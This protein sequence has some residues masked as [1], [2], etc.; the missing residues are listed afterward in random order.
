METP[1]SEM[2]AAR[3]ELMSEMSEREKFILDLQG[4]S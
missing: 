4:V 1:R 3:G 2:A